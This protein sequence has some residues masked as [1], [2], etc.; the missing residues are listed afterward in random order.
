MT[1]S[2]TTLKR[3]RLQAMV[4]HRVYQQVALLAEQE[5]RSASLMASILI[6]EAIEYREALNKDSKKAAC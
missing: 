1:T 4:D 6:E 5:V 3:Q 2:N